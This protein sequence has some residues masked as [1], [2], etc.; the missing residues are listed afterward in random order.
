MAYLFYEIESET[1]A[2]VYGVNDNPNDLLTEDQKA[3]AI[4][5]TEVPKEKYIE[6]KYPQY[7]VNPQTKEVW[8]EYKERALT[9]E[10][11]LQQLQQDNANI[12]MQLADAQAKL[13]ESESK[14]VQ[15]QG[16]LANVTMQLAMK[17]VL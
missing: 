2:R 12:A 15:L 4:E 1:R 17:G 13:A 3:M 8:I 10:E 16:D 11:Q 5:V 7:Y 14:N 6:G 9:V